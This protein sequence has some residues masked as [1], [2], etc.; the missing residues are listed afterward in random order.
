MSFKPRNRVIQI[1][2]VIT[3]KDKN[4]RM[5]PKRE[6]IKFLIQ[7]VRRMKIIKMKKKIKLFVLRRS[8]LRRQR[9][10]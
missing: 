10:M 3:L 5:M 7:M 1:M 8:S 4:K 2:K 6:I 9:K